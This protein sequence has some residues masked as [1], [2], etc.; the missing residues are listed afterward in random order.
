MRYIDRL[1]RAP[2]KEAPFLPVLRPHDWPL[3]TQCANRSLLRF[4]PGAGVPLVAVGKARGQGFDLVRHDSLAE[5]GLSFD[6]LEDFST[7][8]LLVKPVDW[9]V[10]H[11]NEGTGRPTML[12][13]PD[14]GVVTA[15]RILQV[16][17]LQR[18]HALIGSP[19]LLAGVPTQHHL[20]VCDGSPMADLRLR[21]AFSVWVERHYTA[22]EGIDA[23]SDT[24][25]VVRDG[26]PIGTSVLP[27]D[28]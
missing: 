1:R 21:K 6:E 3:L 15:S 2:P 24:V 20:F 23:L 16:E 26:V 17:L 18:A 11:A 8:N 4:R 13:L 9:E 10:V 7:H 19:V 27:E 22:A 14:E 28:G 25:F 5:L 12:G